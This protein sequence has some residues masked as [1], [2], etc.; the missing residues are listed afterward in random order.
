MK[1][2]KSRRPLYFRMGLYFRMDEVLV[3][4]WFIGFLSFIEKERVKISI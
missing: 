3:S 1:H 2:E 4:S